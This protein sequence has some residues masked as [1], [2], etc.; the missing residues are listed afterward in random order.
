[1][2]KIKFVL[3]S[4]LFP[5]VLCAQQANEYSGKFTE[6]DRYAQVLLKDWVIPGMAIVIV[7]KDKPIYARG[8][9][10]ANVESNTSVTPA[11]LFPIASNT[12]LFTAILAAQLEAEGKIDLDLPIIT[13]IPGIE[14]NNDELSLKITMRDLLSHRTGLA[15]YDGIWIAAP[16]SRQD[17]L[18]KLKYIKP[19]L[20]FREGYIYSNNMYST[21]GIVIERVTGK[22]WEENVR[23]R[24]F[25]PLRMTTSGF[26]DVGPKP[27]LLSS[28][29]SHSKSGELKPRR[30]S[31]QSSALGPAGTIYSNMNEMANWMSALINSGKFE[32]KQVFA[33]EAV[34]ETMVPN[35]I[36]DK[37]GR[38]DELSN[39]IY[40]LGRSL[41]TYKGTK[42]VS[43]TGSIDGFYSN[44]TYLPQDSIAIF[45]VHNSGSA[46][47]LR[48]VI[49]LPIIDILKDR[50]Q[51]DWNGRLRKDYLEARA[52]ELSSEEIMKPTENTVPSHKLTEYVGSYNHPAYGT[53]Q[54]GFK[55][56]R[57]TANFRT[58]NANLKHWH[59]DQ[60]VTVEDENSGYELR[61]NFVTDNK[62]DISKIL[63]RP[64]GDPETEFTRTKD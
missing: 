12:K 1:M 21:A 29:Y 45:A 4:V 54:I 24:I 38:Y 60:F 52:R 3:L 9:G 20:G 36:S 40:A 48:S 10:L 15:S 11:T 53:I 42:I 58:I 6:I 22:S 47:S 46:G 30:N 19:G 59:Y 25:K 34:A 16:F 43:H 51:T 62:G 8:F 64:F 33:P 39:S 7:H 31:S 57:L 35:A 49:N 17:L 56:N 44:L 63:V 28:S 41:Q 26:S 18:S 50:E 32:G 5:V 13:Y 55:D 2:K 23:E 14:F 37:R 27:K 61:L